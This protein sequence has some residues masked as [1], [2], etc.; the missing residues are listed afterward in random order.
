MRDTDW[1]DADGLA[2]GMDAE[3]RKWFLGDF[4]PSLPV[5]VIGKVTFQEVTDEGLIVKD[6][7]GNSQLVEGNT[8]VF[9]AGLKSVNS[10][11]EKLTG[12]VPELYE[13]GDCIK[14]Q[15]IMDA[16]AEGA[17]IARLV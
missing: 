8:M 3:M 2:C 10:L 6:R 12:K 4:L 11:K 1:S 16:T 5:D 14:A 7:E 9:A 15:K 17:R 13:V